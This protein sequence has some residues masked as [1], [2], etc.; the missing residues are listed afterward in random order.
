LFKDVYHRRGVP[1]GGDGGA[2][3]DIVVESDTNLH[4]LLDFKYTQHYRAEDG[5]NGGSSNKYGRRGKDL[6]IKVPVG[7]IIKD[8][9]L[10]LLLRDLAAPGERVVVAKGGAGGKGNSKRQ[11]ATPGHLGEVKTLYFELKL[12]ADAGIIGLPNAGKSTLVSHVSKAK[13][14]IAPYP[15]TTKNPILGVVRV[16]DDKSFVIADMPGLIEGAHHGRG[17]GDKFLR[18]IERTTVLV[19]IVDM[20]PPDG[21]LPFENY[22]KLENELKLYSKNVYNKPRV[23]VVNKM[24]LPEA[25]D[26][27]K[28]FKKKMRK[29]IFQISA[30]TGEGL[31]ELVKEIYDKIRKAKKKTQEDND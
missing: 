1:D 14:K 25:K 4:T 2:G 26:N 24:D 31:K 6:V 11:D 13:S 9:G 10:G 28:Q 8:A 29:K 16:F 27:L 30:L 12:V 15:F 20:V 18:H 7:T 21:S 22:L 23:I 3:G 5:K 19:H 17:L